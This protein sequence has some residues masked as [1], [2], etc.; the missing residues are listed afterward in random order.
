MNIARMIARRVCVAR[1]DARVLDVAGSVVVVFGES[2]DDAG[3][4]AYEVA[5][6][7]PAVSASVVHTM[8][9]EG[10]APLLEVDAATISDAT[11]ASLGALG[12]RLRWVNVEL[13]RDLQT[14]IDVATNR[15]VVVRRVRDGEA[16]AVGV[17]AREAFGQPPPGLPRID[18]EHVRKAWM[19]YCRSPDVRVFLAE[20][21]GA[22]RA[23][24]FSL[25][26]GD[27]AFVDGA[28]TLAAYRRK[29]C[30]AALLACRLE[31][32]RAAGA[33]VAVTRTAEGSA[34]AKG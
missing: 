8:R 14:P 4:R 34:S 17:L 1:A 27:L 25:I 10:R 7:D 30:Q 21:D 15:D 13:R 12:L 29:G 20:V 5:G 26:D 31:D 32:A 2:P 6:M 18:G 23:M 24:G 11:R 16:E 33:A 9:A 22:P 28:A 19:A 3:N